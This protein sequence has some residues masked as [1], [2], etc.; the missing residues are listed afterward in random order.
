MSTSMFTGSPGAAAPSVVAASVCGIRATWISGP[1]SAATV[2][3]TPSTVIEPLWTTY[4]SSSSGMR[5]V[6]VAP[7]SASRSIAA[8]RPTPSTWPWTRWPPSRAANVT[9]RS[10]L[11]V[12]PARTDPRLVRLSV[13]PLRS[14]A[15]VASVRSTT[16]KQVPL[17]ATDAP[18]GLSVATSGQR[19]TSRPPSSA[20][21]VPSSSTIPVNIS[22][23]PDVGADAVDPNERQVQRR[24]DRREPLPHHRARRVG[25][26]DDPRRDVL[27]DAVDG[28]VAQEAPRQRG[29]P[30]E[31]HALDVA[32]A[33]RFEQRT[34][35]DA[36]H[37]V[38]G[39]DRDLD[40]GRQRP[41]YGGL[42]RSGRGQECGRAIVEDRSGRG[43]RARRV[44]DHPK[45]RPRR[46][47]PG[48]TRGER[49]VVGEGGAGADEDRI[50]PGAQR[51]GVE[52]SGLRGDPPRGAVASRGLAV[53]RR[54]QLPDH[55]RGSRR[56][57]A[58]ERGIQ[59]MRLIGENA[60]AHVDAGVT[61][62][63]DPGPLHE[64]VWI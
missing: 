47:E 4:A 50:G 8:I 14:N 15:S 13:S 22:L 51:V 33:E 56:H 48:V 5:T 40:A 57:V 27:D 41:R 29:A 59:A 42:A 16:V 61:Q 6:T 37:R 23:H 2:R 20:C 30:F 9:G 35:R 19:T 24:A 10:R 60:G 64:R 45:G 55:E 17:T 31:Q 38:R 12:A 52:G 49:R 11:T 43:D 32:F 25:A 3:L 63:C 18:I 21:T 62:P 53:E 39:T 1:S 36:A 26:A 7:P 58:L 46:S 54:G 44:D 34:R 28:V